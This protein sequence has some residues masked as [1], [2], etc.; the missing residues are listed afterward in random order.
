MG[1]VLFDISMSLD[2]FITGPDVSLENPMGVGGERLHDW[3][4][5]L[6][7]WREHHQL[8]GGTTGQDSDIIE[9]AFSQTGAII[10][11][12]NM[13]DDAERPWGDTPPFHMPVFVVTHEAREP[14]VKGDTT[15]FFVTDGIESALQRAKIAAGDKDISIGG[16]ADIFQQ[17]LS[18][19]L[20][21][22]FQIHVVPLL[23]GDGTRLFGPRVHEI[24]LEITR[25]VSSPAVTRLRYRPLRS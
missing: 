5:G 2:G 23:L 25:V 16:G 14:L 24:D 1:R 3:L 12:R 17:Y 6:E 13:F 18:A 10:I 7:S 11:G 22:E 8:E 4:Y 15:F 20:V 9:E 19:G 21:D